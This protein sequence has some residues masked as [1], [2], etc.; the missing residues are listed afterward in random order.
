MSGPNDGGPAFPV[1]SE[2]LHSISEMLESLLPGPTRDQIAEKAAEM[3][4]GQ[5]LRDFFAIHAL[6]IEAARWPEQYPQGRIGVARA[7]YKMADAMLDAR[8]EAK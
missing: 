5:S 8:K 4:M 1:S 6:P 3:S 7:A 2:A